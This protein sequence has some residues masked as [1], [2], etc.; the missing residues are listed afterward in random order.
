MEGFIYNCPM[1]CPIG[2]SC[3]VV[4]T[5]SELKEPLVVLKKCAAEK[6]KDIKVSIGGDQKRERPP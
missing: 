6:G 1:R 2:K 3:F 5:A 4:K